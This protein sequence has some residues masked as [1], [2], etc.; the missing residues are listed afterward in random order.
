LNFEIRPGDEGE[1]SELPALEQLV[2]MGYEYKT[3]SELM[4]ERRKKT[5]VLL[6]DRIKSAIE[7]LNKDENLT[8]E[9]VQDALDKISEDSFS[10]TL[11]HMDANEKIH[12]MLTSVSRSGGLVPIQVNSI[13]PDKDNIDIKLIDF[14]NPENNDFIVT[15]QFKLVGDKDDIIPDIVIFVNG[16]PIVVIECKSPYIPKPIEQAVEKNLKKYQRRDEGWDKLFFYNLF[17]VATCGIEARHGTIGADVNHYAPWTESYPLTT[18]EVAK[19]CTVEPR[20]QEFL[21]AGMLSHQ[22]LLEY[23][24]N[25]IV[26]DTVNEKKIKKIAK[27]QQFRAVIKAAKR[28]TEV[29]TK[30]GGVIWH[31]QGSGKSLTMFWLASR[32]IKDLN[33]PPI[34]IVTDRKQ[35]DKQIIDTFSNAGY[36]SAKRAKDTDDLLKFLA[37]PKGKTLMT[38]IQ[39]FDRKKPMTIN[40]DEKILVLVD[41]AHRSQYDEYNEAMDKALADKGI[42]FGFT[43]TPID[44]KDKSTYRVFGELIDSYTF[45]ESKADGA[46]LRILHQEKLPQL[47]L[48]GDETIDQIFERVFADLDPETKARLK[49][50]C[51][52]KEAIAMAP[53]R[54][55]KIAL[56]IV[57]HYTKHIM[58]NGYKAMIVAVN[59]A[60]AVRYKKALDELNAPPSKIIMS[61]TKDEKGPNGENWDDYYLT[62]KQ[63]EVET[64]QFKDPDDP[65]KILIVVD[66]LLVGFDA[67]PVQVL[68]LDH[69]L[70]E[71]ALLQAIARVN[72]P[73]DENKDHGLIVDYWGVTTNLEEALGIFKDQDIKGAME[74]I[75]TL[76]VNLKARHQKAMSHFSDIDKDNDNQ[77]I[78]K[79]V[80]V[81]L[82][83][84]FDFDF[85]ELTKALNGVMPDKAADP[86][87][88]DFKFLIKKREIIKRWYEGTKPSIRPYAP[89]VQKLIDEHI[90]SLGTIE[91]LPPTEITEGKFDTKRVDGWLDHYDLTR[92]QSH[93]SGHSK[94]QYLLDI[95]KTIDA[96]MLFPIHTEHPD[97]YK[98]VTNKITIVDEGKKYKI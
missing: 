74:P 14:E 6:Y 84:E 82:R 70:K 28:A 19:L 40:T 64:E 85:R 57:D 27:H 42:F 71:H 88:D 15:N 11:H 7:R 23:M 95:V 17:L 39:K 63:V 9:Q 33:N 72:R 55:K 68:Y 93:C 52:D 51:V 60:A 96:K 43:G 58:P 56:D 80:H 79:F 46:T 66:M 8:P 26:Y 69:P 90:R 29:T 49:R 16:F 20:Q 34:L 13:D 78:A 3:Q 32:V 81:N 91:L 50:E 98:K 31:T 44:K 24:K 53:A 4:K 92:I 67:P 41:E 21:I 87:L 5:E 45:E 37:N 86:Y 94:G 61:M 76:L 83:A 25:F 47:F 54:I 89:K 77:I 65:T 22:H 35:L 2:A 12:A 18:E 1:K 30:K 48:E 38:T 10:P 62:E 36:S 59:R 73:F 75:V 97:A